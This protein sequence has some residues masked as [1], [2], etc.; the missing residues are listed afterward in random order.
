MS[1]FLLLLGPSGVGKSAIIEELSKLDDRFVYICPYM[2]RPLRTGETN[3]VAVSGSEMDEM[4]QHGKLLVVNEL[5]GGIRYGTPRLPIEE[6]LVIGKFPVLDWPIDRLEVMTTA[7]SGQLFVVYVSPPSLEVL[8]QRM[9]KDGRD[10]DGAR[11]ASAQ[12]ELQRFWAL[13]YVGN[14]D[15]EI[16]SQDGHVSEIARAIYSNYIQSF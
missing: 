7:F 9:G 15:Y 14:Y 5:F 11:F 6:A 4:W 3:K 10:A 13:G 1:K 12:K 2:T 16:V 8:R